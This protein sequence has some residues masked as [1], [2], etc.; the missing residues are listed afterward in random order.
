MQRLAAPIAW[1][2]PGHAAR[3]LAGFARAEQGSRID[4]L[5]AAHLTSSPARRAAYL[6]HAADETRHARLFWRR[7]CDLADA[8]LPAP[9]ADS[10]DLF[11]RLGE[12]R[13]LAFVHRGE[14]RGRIQ[15]ET[16][17][18]QLARRDARTAAL[19]TGIVEDERRHEA[20]TGELLVALVGAARARREL[21]RAAMW[22]AWR[23]WRRAGRALANVAFVV[24]MT[25]VYVIVAPVA[26][27]ARL[28]ARRRTGW[29]ASP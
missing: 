20:Y 18:R 14:R 13:F 6:R 11:A 16:Y 29:M 24:A 5:A 7:A 10:E 21:R 3:T 17:A 8:P 2:I 12:P 1:R 25:A 19:F 27:L 15:F 26:R 23:T 9:R 4:L 28:V 22:E